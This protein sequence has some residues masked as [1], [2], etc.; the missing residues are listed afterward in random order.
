MALAIHWEVGGGLA[1]TLA[2]V[3]RTIRDRIELDRRIR[4]QGVEAHASVAAVMAI[5]YLLA[6]LMWRTSPERVEAFVGSE[7]GTVL[8]AI[9]VGLQAVG[10]LWMSRVSRSGF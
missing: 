10:L 5:T 3:G 6:Y 2:T 7:I 9:V 4:A 1:A 8:V